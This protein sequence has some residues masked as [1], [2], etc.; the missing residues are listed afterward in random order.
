LV[1][2]DD[3]GLDRLVG[4]HGLLLFHLFLSPSP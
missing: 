2:F 4:R 3:D 1:L